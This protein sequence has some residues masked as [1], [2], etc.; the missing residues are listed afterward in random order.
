MGPYSKL[1]ARPPGPLDFPR[2]FNPHAVNIWFTACS[3]LPSDPRSA[4]V[5][6][7]HT[8]KEGCKSA[9]LSPFAEPGQ[10]TDIAIRNYLYGQRRHLVRFLNVTRMMV[11]L[12]V[13]H[14][15][16]RE[17]RVETYG[18][19]IMIEAQMRIKDP[20]W[21]QS[22]FRMNGGYRFNRIRDSKRRYVLMLDPGLIVFVYNQQIANP[23]RWFIGYEIR[24]PLQPSYKSDTDMD[25]ESK[26]QFILDQLWKPL[27]NTY[28]G[29]DLDRI[30]HL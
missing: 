30:R 19:S 6:A 18:F 17:A 14:N 29:R 20:N 9:G 24:T 25:L 16:R 7:L 12:K 8:Y 2:N 4:W 1:L 10:D 22:L 23:D 28:R 13:L 3:D 11:G 21:V 27:M 5:A 15:L 26:S